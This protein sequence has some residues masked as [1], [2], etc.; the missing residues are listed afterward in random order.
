MSYC[1]SIKMYII[2]LNFIASNITLYCLRVRSFAFNFSHNI[3]T[4]Y[5]KFYYTC[6]S[7]NYNILIDILIRIVF[8]LERQWWGSR[9]FGL[10]TFLVRQLYCIMYDIYLT[11]TKSLFL[12]I[13]LKIQI[14]STRVALYKIFLSH[15]SITME[16][17]IMCYIYVVLYFY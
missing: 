6:H 4:L 1:D 17:F 11:L 5:T 9:W 7:Y 8:V 15:I 3:F 16:I 2:L 12:K 13:K 10:K 14:W